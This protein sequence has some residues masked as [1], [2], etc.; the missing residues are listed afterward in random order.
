MNFRL[1]NSEES[2]CKTDRQSTKS[3]NQLQKSNQQSP[4]NDRLLPIP[5][6][7]RGASGACIFGA[8]QHQRFSFPRTPE[9]HNQ[10]FV[11]LSH[12]EMTTVC[13]QRQLPSWPDSLMSLQLTITTKLISRVAR[14]F[15]NSESNGRFETRLQNHQLTTQKD[16]PPLLFWSLDEWQ[17]RLRL[18]H[19]WLFLSSYSIIV[20]CIVCMSFL[21]MVSTDL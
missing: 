11:L 21:Y 2:S 8:L 5:S 7:W 13:V 20:P 4:T 12:R 14:P 10:N 6:L 18:V 3:S 15:S 1:V 16:L 9:R 17:V 19:I